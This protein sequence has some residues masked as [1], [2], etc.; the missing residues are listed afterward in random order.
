MPDRLLDRD[1]TAEHPHN[2]MRPATAQ[3]LEIYNLAQNTTVGFCRDRSAIR[4]QNHPKPIWD[5]GRSVDLPIEHLCERVVA[6]ARQLAEAIGAQ[7]TA[8]RYLR[9]QRQ[10]PCLQVALEPAR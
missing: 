6:R 9:N 2:P 1:A 7:V 10:D 4:F 8:L 3:T 5:D